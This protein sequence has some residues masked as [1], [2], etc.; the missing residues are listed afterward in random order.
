M[1]NRD[2]VIVVDVQNDFCP[3]GSLAVTGGDEVV[4]VA[5]ALTA[6]ARGRSVPVVFTR[7]WHVPDAEHFKTWPSHCVQN[8]PGAE[9]HHLLDI[10]RT[11]AVVSKGTDK[12]GDAYSGFEGLTA[13]GHSLEAY[14][15]ARGIRRVWLMGLA[16]DFCVWKTAE[17][18]IRFGFETRLVLEGCRSVNLTPGAG[19]AAIREM[20]K[21]GVRVVSLEYALAYLGHV[22]T[23]IDKRE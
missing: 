7:D 4:G 16:T 13:E 15:E 19:E 8:T 20:L 18:A 5:N 2:A 22:S 1:N 23:F 12:I 14:L 6:C 10:R 11:D 9:F 21:V 17:D 3:G